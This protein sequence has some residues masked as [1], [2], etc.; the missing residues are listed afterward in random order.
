MSCSRARLTHGGDDGR[1]ILRSRCAAPSPVE[2]GL[3]ISIIARS[4]AFA[5]LFVAVA[6]LERVL[7]GYIHGPSVAQSIPAYGG[8]GLVGRSVIGLVI[9][10]SLIPYC[11]FQDVDLVLGRGR[12]ADLLV[13]RGLL[14]REGEANT[15][16]LERVRRSC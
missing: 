7:L 11:A 13:R 8:G 3:F 12:L 16:A 4:I 10:M 15:R 5:L 9:A 1:H 6:V 14:V 2:E